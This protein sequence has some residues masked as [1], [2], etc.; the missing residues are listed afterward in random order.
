MTLDGPAPGKVIALPHSG[1]RMTCSPRGRSRVIAL[2][3]TRSCLRAGRRLVDGWLCADDLP[4]D[5][6][7]AP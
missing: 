7:Q 1:S 3:L 6:A 5:G 2:P 4:F